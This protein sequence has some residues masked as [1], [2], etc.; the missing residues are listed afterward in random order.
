MCYLAACRSFEWSNIS[1]STTFVLCESKNQF[2]SDLG[3]CVIIYALFGFL[4]FDA[5]RQLRSKNM[6]NIELLFQKTLNPEILIVRFSFT[7]LNKK[8]ICIQSDSIVNGIFYPWVLGILSEF[9][10]CIISK[11]KFLCIQFFSVVLLPE[12]NPSEISYLFFC[13]ATSFVNFLHRCYSKKCTVF[14][15]LISKASS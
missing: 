14:N 13:F 12:S 8:Q 7:W 15:K 6:K 1:P 10:C 5:L 3:I 11:T 4:I 9:K 2:G